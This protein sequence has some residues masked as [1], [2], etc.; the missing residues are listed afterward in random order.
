MSDGDLKS[1]KEGIESLLKSGSDREE[2]ELEK[3]FNEKIRQERRKR[4]NKNKKISKEI[5]KLK[6]LTSR[7]KTTLYWIAISSFTLLLAN[8]C[9]NAVR[10]IAWLRSDQ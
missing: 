9:I 8:T 2:R 4:K 6:I 5:Q 10:F 7:E 1:I 3:E